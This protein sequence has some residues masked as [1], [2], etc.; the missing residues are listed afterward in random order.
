MLC[1]KILRL[2]PTAALLLLGSHISY[3][4]HNSDKTDY[5]YYTIIDHQVNVGFQTTKTI[6]FDLTKQIPPS[7]KKNNTKRHYNS[8]M[9]YAQLLLSKKFRIE[10]GL[11]LNMIQMTGEAT[12][13]F[14]KYVFTDQ[15]GISVPVTVQYYFG[16][17]N[18]RVKPYIGAGIQYNSNFNNKRVIE[19]QPDYI[20]QTGTR[21]ISILFTQGLIYE[22]NTKIQVMEHL[23]FLP[24]EGVKTMG[25]DV[26]IGFKLQ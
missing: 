4:Q 6:L 24:S 1:N 22:V 7:K 3:A 17:K 26:G 25:L 9:V 10:T 14:N 20:P 11:S 12:S 18:K 21:F 15:Y 16:K 23:H 19:D 2:I 5:K 8:A 13:P